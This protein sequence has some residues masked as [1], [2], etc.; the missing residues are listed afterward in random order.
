MDL[1]KLQSDIGEKIIAAAVMNDV[2]AL[3]I[4]GAILDF[5]SGARG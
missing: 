2:A 1:G 5:Q 3:L 4:L